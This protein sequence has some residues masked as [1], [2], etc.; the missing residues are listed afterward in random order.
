LLKALRGV[1]VAGLGL[2]NC[3][4]KVWTVSEQVVRALLLAPA[5]LAANED[6][7]AVGEGP[8]LVD[9]TGT[10][11]PIA[12]LPVRRPSRRGRS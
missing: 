5:G 6:N 7:P 11:N 9:R 2:N 4:R 10:I 12:A 1:P 8:L 3:D